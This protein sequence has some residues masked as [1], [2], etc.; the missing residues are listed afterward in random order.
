M[1]G[2]IFTSFQTTA[3]ALTA[4]RLRMD[5]ISNNIANSET[6][7]TKNGGPYQRQQVVFVAKSGKGSF[8]SHLASAKRGNTLDAPGR[9]V[10]V[11]SIIADDS[12]GNTI[13]DPTHPD[14]DEDGFVTYPNVN[15]VTEMTDMLS[16]TRSYEANVTV[17]NALKSMA[18]KAIELGNK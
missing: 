1:S 3:S 6:T 8:A 11:S 13:Y 10:E 9:G 18:L 17:F 14:A 4:Q 12:P 7:R 15:I 5:V 16:A 2:G